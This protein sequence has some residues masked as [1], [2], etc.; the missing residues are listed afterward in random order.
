MINSPVLKHTIFVGL[1]LLFLPALQQ[2]HTLSLISII[3][4]LAFI[5][6][7]PVGRED[8]IKKFLVVPAGLW[9]VIAILTHDYA[10]LILVAAFPA[11]LEDDGGSKTADY[12]RRLVWLATAVAIWQFLADGTNLMERAYNHV[13]ALIAVFLTLVDSS[14]S[15][16]APALS[17]Q[18]T[19][20]D[21]DDSGASTTGKSFGDFLSMS[22][23]TAILKMDYTDFNRESV[24][25][26][27]LDTLCSGRGAKFAAYYELDGDNYVL[28]QTAGNSPLKLQKSYPIGVGMVGQVHT[29]G[30]YIYANNLQKKEP[31]KTKRSL[32]RGM[33]SLLSVPVVVNQEQVGV[34]YVGFPHHSEEEQSMLIELCSIVA[35]KLGNEFEKQS[36]HYKVEKK[37][38]T[39][40]LTGLYNRQF[41]DDIFEKEFQQ[42]KQNGTN[43]AYVLLDLDFF[44]QMNDTHGHD[45]G[46]KV[47]KLASQTFA[48]NIRKTDY[49]CRTGGDEF[50][51]VITNASKETVYG[52]VKRIRDEYTKI[53]EENEL[54]AELNGKHVKSSLS[55]GVAVYPHPKATSAKELIKLADLAVY[56]VKE[57]GKNNFCF[58]K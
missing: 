45:F 42:A 27:T 31:D 47:L 28:E 21:D 9:L 49:A 39:D 40:K 16:L 44:K 55:I 20:T 46:D 6:L 14:Q 7:H 12:I 30:S 10:L 38:Q 26:T 5:G 50:S 37:S 8:I 15:H 25:Q 19:E 17:E 51:L 33:D 56:H 2:Q 32:L 3:I 54:Y 1:L 53:V 48:K 58:V 13:P 11:L 52:I 41:F 23:A 22:L 24:I 34:I 4:Y 57:H 43:L 29:S 35:K 18:A 36:V